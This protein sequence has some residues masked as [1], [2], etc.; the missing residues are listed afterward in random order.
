MRPTLF[1]AGLTLLQADIGSGPVDIGVRAAA[2]EAAGV[3]LKRYVQ[4][5]AGAVAPGPAGQ[6]QCLDHKSLHAQLG[7]GDWLRE[8]GFRGGV[9]VGGRVRVT[10]FGCRGAGLGCGRRFRRSR[11]LLR[12]VTVAAASQFCCA[13]CLQCKP[14]SGMACCWHKKKSAKRGVGQ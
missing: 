1:A 8:R 12:G 9:A 4:A 11:G 6:R 14:A 5:T 13:M 7:H 3:I 10:G 2:Q